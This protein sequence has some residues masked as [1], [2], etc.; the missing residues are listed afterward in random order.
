M[1]VPLYHMLPGARP[2]RTIEEMGWDNGQNGNVM[3]LLT[4]CWHPLLKSSW[5]HK[6]ALGYMRRVSLGTYMW[7]N[8]L[9]WVKKGSKW[10]LPSRLHTPNG[11]KFFL[12][13]HFYDPIFNAFVVTKWAIFK[14]FGTLEGPKR[15]PQIGL[16]LGLFHL[17]VHPMYPQLLSQVYRGRRGRRRAGCHKEV[18]G[19]K[20]CFDYFP[21]FVYFNGVSGPLWPKKGLFGAQ[22]V[23]FWE[24][25]S[26]LGAP[27]LRCDR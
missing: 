23:Q 2:Q 13:K 12:E 15:K 18:K 27:A 22:N 4:C 26:P 25:T 7:R 16:K 10:A 8:G 24:G 3:C 19:H 20:E 14:A 17:F 21:S 1:H 9:K 5:L 11:P 6:T